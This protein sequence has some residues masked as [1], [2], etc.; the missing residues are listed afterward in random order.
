VDKIAGYGKVTIEALGRLETR[1]QRFDSD[2][3]E[4]SRSL[5]SIASQL[6]R[7]E[8]LLSVGPGTDSSSVAPSFAKPLPLVRRG[9]ISSLYPTC[10]GVP[11]LSGSRRNSLSSSPIGV[12]QSAIFK[13]IPTASET[14]MQRASKT[15]STAERDP[16]LPPIVLPPISALLNLSDNQMD[17]R[18]DSSFSK[19]FREPKSPEG[20]AILDFFYAF[21][22]LIAYAGGSTPKCLTEYIRYH[23][24]AENTRAHT[25]MLSALAP[26]LN[27][28]ESSTMYLKL[29]GA[30]EKTHDHLRRIEFK[31]D[32][33]RGA[34]WTEGYDVDE[35]DRALKT[36]VAQ[37]TLL[38]MTSDIRQEPTPD[39]QHMGWWDVLYH[40]RPQNWLTKKDR[41]NSWL[42]QNLATQP[43]EA[44]HHRKCLHDIGIGDQL[45]EEEWARLVLKFWA[46]DD[47]AQQLEYTD[48]STNGAVD[49]DGACHSTRV[50][51]FGSLPIREK[52][53]VMDID[54]ESEDSTMNLGAPRKRKR[55]DV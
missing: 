19:L 25:R 18:N 51:L 20:G 3:H 41:I 13:S 28:S 11:P 42:L 44:L 22:G 45:S 30:Q 6:S 48:C 1:F 9:S 7:I 37:D 2:E 34:C 8:S 17:N 31:R 55:G 53:D 33:Y 5:S 21:E 36:A 46:I 29:Q 35:L 43:S 16:T 38:D 10:S 39:K 49:S 50:K 26:Y 4:N 15:V 24:I 47:A 12:G 32:R 54:S 52:L 27:L 40:T 23:Q 14:A